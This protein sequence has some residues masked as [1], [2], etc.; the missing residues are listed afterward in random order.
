M[1]G[2]PHADSFSRAFR[3]IIKTI[4][5]LRIYLEIGCQVD[6][7]PTHPIARPPIFLSLES[8]QDL[9]VMTSL[10]I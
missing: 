2:I 7:L 6:L 10:A 3:N 1:T 8:T 5:L 9:V 4:R